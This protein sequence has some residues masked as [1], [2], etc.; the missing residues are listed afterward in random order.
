[1]ESHYRYG[2][3]TIY[4][5]RY[6]YN[7]LNPSNNYRPIELFPEAVRDIHMDGGTILGSS[8]GGTENMDILMDTLEE[9]KVNILY[10]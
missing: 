1:M 7:G 5:I 6:G 2:A 9:M 3:S 10:I 4:G 8:R